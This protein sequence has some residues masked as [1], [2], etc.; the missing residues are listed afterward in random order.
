MFLGD[1]SLIWVGVLYQSR[2]GVGC[3]LNFRLQFLWS[4][5]FGQNGGIFL[6]RWVPAAVTGYTSSVRRPDGGFAGV[7]T[8]VQGFTVG[9]P[10]WKCEECIHGF[11]T[12]RFC[13]TWNAIENK[14][15]VGFPIV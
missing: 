2:F 12:L 11:L 8:V 3:V 4:L 14:R 9:E 7:G 5:N 6:F 15:V 1:A 13:V 10:L